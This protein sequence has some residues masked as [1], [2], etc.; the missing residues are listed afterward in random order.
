VEESPRFTVDGEALEPYVVSLSSDSSDPNKYYVVRIEEPLSTPPE[1]IDFEVGATLD[2]APLAP[3]RATFSVC[4]G[5]VDS[6]SGSV[7]ETRWQRSSLV[8]ESGGLGHAYLAS[9]SCGFN[10]GGTNG[11]VD[12]CPYYP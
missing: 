11:A 3:H 1:A 9:C 2:A 6:G 7:D 4:L 10:D 12:G 5:V 8:V